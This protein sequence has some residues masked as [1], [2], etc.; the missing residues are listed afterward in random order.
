MKN[1]KIISALAS[2]AIAA[3][4]TFSIGFT[5]LNADDAE[6][7]S[8]GG[9]GGRSFGGGGFSRS[10][11]RSSGSNYSKPSGGFFSS[12]RPTSRPSSSTSNRP[13]SKRLAFK[14]ERMERRN[15]GGFS[16]TGNTASRQQAKA[17]LNA[18]RSKFKTQP[19]K[20][21]NLNTYRSTYGKNPVYQ[22]AG[23]SDSS[24][25]YDRR[26]NYYGGNQPPAYM[27]NSSPSFGMW[28]T[29]FLYMMLSNVN[30]AS[31]FSHNHSGDAD[32]QK[33][34]ADADRLAIDN[35][36]L[37]GQLAAMDAGKAGLAGEAVD[38]A[39][40]PP[41]VDP[42]IAMSEEARKAAMPTF[43]FC[44]GSDSGVYHS[45][46]TKLLAPSLTTVNLVVI[47]TAGTPEILEKVAGGECDGGFVQNDGFWNYVEDHKTTNLDFTQIFSPYKEQV[48]LVCNAASGVE[49]LED[50]RTDGISVY[51]ASKTGGFTTWR[52]L[53]GEDEDYAKV[54]SS[55]SEPT[56]AVASNEEAL[57][58]V[59]GN[60]KACLVYVS[61]PSSAFMHKV[62]KVAAD[63]K[64]RLVE[65]TDDAL[66]EKSTTPSGETIYTSGSIDQYDNLL[67]Y[68]EYLWF[69]G[70]DVDTLNIDTDFIVSNKW[71]TANATVYEKLVVD[72]VSLKSD[73]ETAATAK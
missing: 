37:R 31:A 25:Y 27:Y 44:A 68:T 11:F 42:D 30:N 72:M 49:E 28:D 19:T 58:K 41:G 7:R 21:A 26:A 12:S 13:D 57:N 50:I 70:G 18:Y 73:I 36:E 20:P 22:S 23:R 63:G 47:N 35:Q 60:E 53:A 55:V 67:K 4:A 34:R 62:D 56:L 71:K 54:V 17:S 3:V 15:V 65:F 14:S 10:T 38:P 46:A 6:A 16:G 61:G 66:V 32:Y 5:A 24:T 45:I 43:K 51:A 48:H 52:N 40:L 33:W 2:V 39:F 1:M 59:L 69:F 8:F 9:G 64:I 29:M